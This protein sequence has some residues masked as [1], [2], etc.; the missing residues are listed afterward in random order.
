MTW[1]PSARAVVEVRALEERP[2][3]ARL[4]G[5]RRV[6]QPLLGGA[7]E[8][9]PVEVALVEVLVPG[10]AVG[11]E[12]D[13]RERA[14]PLRD[15]AQLGERDRV[16]AAEREREGAGL[17][18][19][20]QRLLDA[21]VRALGVPGRNRQVAVVDDRQRIAEVD[22]EA[23]VEGPQQR[24]SGADRLGPEARARPE[25]DGGVERDPVD[26]CVDARQVGDVRQPHERPHAR[27]A[28]VDASVDR[29]VR[30]PRHAV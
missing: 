30:R 21:P 28:R 3:H 5:R 17:H 25:G 4:H 14:V 20:R 26:G 8:R 15:D 19:G 6:D 13:E 23:G 18:H 1:K 22:A 24:G 9:R 11:V 2:A 29:P 27:E 16:V 10:V 7:P 12:L